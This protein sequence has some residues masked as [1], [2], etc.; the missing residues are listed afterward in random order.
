MSFS[1]DLREEIAHQPIKHPCCRLALLAAALRGAGTLHLTGGGHTHGEIDVGE[2][3]AARLLVR[4]LRA[5][6]A[7]CEIRTYRSSRL[8]SSQ[9]L[10]IVLAEDEQTQALLA[11]VGVIDRHGRPLPFVAGLIVARAC[12]RR[13]LLRG[14]FLV[15]GSVSPPGRASL[16][17]IRTHDVAFAEGLAACAERFE[18]P[19]R[20][21]ERERWAE[22]MTRRRDVVQDLLT[23]LGAAVGALDMAED[24]VVR[25]ARADANRRAN[26]D[27]ANLQ[28]QIMAARRQLGA[29]KKLGQCGLIES[30]SEPLQTAARLRLA[31]PEMSLTELAEEGGL[32]RPTLAARLRS[33]V[34]E[35]E[36]AWEVEELRRPPA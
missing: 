30:L 5:E 28:R 29:I 22:V 27:L 34:A 33:L 1:S 25:T 6:G 16:L 18:I 32:A 20:V 8:S 4:A 7:T 9:R 13:A 26:F 15:G 17:E 19:L 3:A 12:C 24:D 35:G 21:R 10:L 36:A 11:R 23:V 2:H 14:A 31:H